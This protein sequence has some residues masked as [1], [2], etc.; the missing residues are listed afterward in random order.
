VIPLCLLA[1]PSHN[2]KIEQQTPSPYGQAQC[3]NKLGKYINRQ[4]RNLTDDSMAAIRTASSKTSFSIQA[5]RPLKIISHHG[6]SPRRLNMCSLLLTGGTT[7]FSILTGPDCTPWTTRGEEGGKGK[8]EVKGLRHRTVE[9]L[10]G[11]NNIRRLGPKRRKKISY[12]H[13]KTRREGLRLCSTS[14]HKVG[15]VSAP[16]AC[17]DCATC[18]NAVQ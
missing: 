5:T 17:P 15:G 13:A 6:V 16:H 4:Q 7:I 11:R 12:L 9:P 18:M 8:T 2:H 1:H 3:A 10:G 14:V